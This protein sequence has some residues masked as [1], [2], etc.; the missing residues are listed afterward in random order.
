[1]NE[2]DV[3]GAG[4]SQSLRNRQIGL[5]LIDRLPRMSNRAIDH[6]NRWIRRVT[7]DVFNKVRLARVRVDGHLARIED[8]RLGNN[9]VVVT[10]DWICHAAE[11]STT[12]GF[13]LTIAAIGPCRSKDHVRIENV[14]VGHFQL[15]LN[16][17]K[18]IPLDSGLPARESVE[19]LTL[20]V[21]PAT[22]HADIVPLHHAPWDRRNNFHVDP[23]ECAADARFGCGGH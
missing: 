6:R 17:R 3:A 15:Q 9:D 18:Q 5:C 19:I 14:V 4:L 13:G 7:G 21:V 8:A 2:D 16:I 20:I 10:S 11:L 22:C 12:L 23:G 1:M